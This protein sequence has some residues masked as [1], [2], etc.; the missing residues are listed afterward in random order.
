MQGAQ[1]GTQS[2]V[3]RI[4]SWTE[5]GTK[6]LSHLGGPFLGFLEVFFLK[7]LFI[8]LREKEH[9]LGG[10]EA[11]EKQAPHEW[12]TPHGLHPRTLRS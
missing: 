11:R 3:S 2:Q 6:P 1:R 8:Y 4:M 9:E 7:I 5:G 10:T 12:G